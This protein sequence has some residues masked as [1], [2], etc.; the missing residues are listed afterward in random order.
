MKTTKKSVLKSF[1][2]C[3]EEIYRKIEKSGSFSGYLQVGNKHNGHHN[4]TLNYEN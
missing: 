2:G 1:T 4:K 3:H